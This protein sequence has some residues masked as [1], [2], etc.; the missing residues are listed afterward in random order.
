M[1]PGGAQLFV[2]FRADMSSELFRRAL[3]SGA[4]RS[5]LVVFV[6]LVQ[7]ISLADKRVRPI[8]TLVRSDLPESGV[9]I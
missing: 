6:P 4:I 5:G 8:E 3:E 1:V 9:V 7:E 2:E